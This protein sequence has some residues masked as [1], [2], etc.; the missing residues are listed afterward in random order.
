MQEKD[1]AICLRCVNYS[2]TSQVV[3]LLTRAHGK[4]ACM[5]KGSKRPKSATDGPIELFSFGPVVFS[6]PKEEGLAALREFP[7][8]SRFRPLRQNLFVLNCGLLAAELIESFTENSDPHEGLFDTFVQFLDTVGTRRQ[9]NL[10]LADLIAFEL[11]LLN[12][13][14]VGLVT[15]R[16][17]NCSTAFSNHWKSAYFSNEVNGLVCPACESSF[18]DKTRLD[19]AAAAGL[20]QMENLKKLPPPALE[21]LHKAMLRHFTAL[22]HRPPKLASFFLSQ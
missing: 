14:G 19:V 3:T 17:A 4:I 5:A 2:E 12:E 13:I 11:T 8:E 6:A 9:K 21:T 16:C 18:I 1:T 20:S 22:L 7:Q 10:Q 15:Q